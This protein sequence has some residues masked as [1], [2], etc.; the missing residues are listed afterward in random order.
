MADPFSPSSTEA[1]L[2]A[3]GVGIWI[4]GLSGQC[5]TLSTLAARL[6]GTEMQTVSHGQLL[7]LVHPHDQRAMERLLQDCLY[8]NRLLDID[9]RIADGQW[10]RIRGQARAD[11]ETARGVLL[12]IGGRRSAQMADSRLAAIVFS[13]DDAIVGKTI[14][15]IVTDWNR[16]AQL[17]FG[18]SADEMIGRPISLLLPPGLEGEEEA[19][20]ERIKRGE[21]IDHF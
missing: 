20:L 12:D 7:Q 10:R 11:S 14:D 19:I 4:W 13:S 17:I 8:S 2:E 18:Y 3:A 21:R 15:G 5:V 16:G 9:F 6:L 1:A